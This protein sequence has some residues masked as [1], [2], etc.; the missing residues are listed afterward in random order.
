MH[1]LVELYDLHVS[2]VNEIIYLLAG[3]FLC[4]ISDYVVSD[5]ENYDRVAGVHVYANEQNHE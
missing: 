5:I 4:G 3:L 2:K 1:A